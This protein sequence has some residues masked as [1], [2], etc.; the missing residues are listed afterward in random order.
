MSEW[1]RVEDA[2]PEHFGSYLVT[3]ASEYKPFVTVMKYDTY[4][5]RWYNP[6]DHRITHWMPFPEAAKGDNTV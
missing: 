4:A 2:L 3:I 6:F 5:K 1:I